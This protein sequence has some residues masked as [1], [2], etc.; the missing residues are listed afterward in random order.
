M[1]PTAPGFVLQGTAGPEGRV[2]V[3]GAGARGDG[4]SNPTTGAAGQDL[5][6]SLCGNHGE[7]PQGPGKAGACLVS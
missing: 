3:G 1:F 7:L 2:G 5:G 4:E 6:S